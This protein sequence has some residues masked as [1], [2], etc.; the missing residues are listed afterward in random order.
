MKKALLLFLLLYGLGFAQETMTGTFLETIVLP[1]SSGNEYYITFKIPYSKLYFIKSDNLFNTQFSIS[2]EAVDSISGKI[3]REINYHNFAVRTYDETKLEDKYFQGVV[4]L[5]LP[6]G[7]YNISS[8]YSNENTKTQNYLENI[9]ENLNT[10][11][12]KLFYKPLIVSSKKVYCNNDSSYVMAN[13]EGNVPFSSSGYDLILPVND[14]T[15]TEINVEMVNNDSSVFNNNLKESFISNYEIST[16]GNNIICKSSSGL[17]TRNFVIRGFNLNLAEGS[18]V[19]NIKNGKTSEKFSKNVTWYNKPFTLAN[20]SYA[21]RLLK[22]VTDDPQ[23]LRLVRVVTN[24]SVKMFNDFWKRIDPTPES[25]FN[26]LLDEFYTRADYA[27]RKFST[28]NKSG[29]DTDRGKIY[30]Q[31]GKPDDIERLY[32]ENKSTQE[33]WHYKSPDRKFIFTDKTGLGNFILENKPL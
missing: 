19:I 11:T 20:F 3:F 15:I 1:S 2:F 21:V 5:N 31:F 13:F 32:A 33:V 17:K 27:V 28:V 22:Y 18:L 29:A 4:K 6:R 9:Y 26:E 30:I 14:T 10:G 23:M 8:V 25:A 7:V 24:K 12:E 16:C